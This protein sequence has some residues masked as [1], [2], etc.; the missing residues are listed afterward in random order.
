MNNNC[1]CYCLSG[2][3][4]TSGPWAHFYLVGRFQESVYGK[5]S[6]HPTLRIMYWGP[7]WQFIDDLTDLRAGHQTTTSVYFYHYRRDHLQ[8]SL[9]E[10]MGVDELV[11]QQVAEATGC[12]PQ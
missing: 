10:A 7:T 3:C 5:S 9:D 12:V 1:D 8:P 2:S 6:I 11:E 4:P